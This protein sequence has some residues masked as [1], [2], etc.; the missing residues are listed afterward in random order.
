MAN[1]PLNCPYCDAER[2]GSSDEYECGMFSDGR[3]PKC[4]ERQITKLEDEKALLSMTVTAL[5]KNKNKLQ[6]RIAELEARNTEYLEALQ[7]IHN[8]AHDLSTGPTVPDGFWELREIAGG[9]L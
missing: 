8:K 7:E 5:D 4:Y 9:C 2:C 1:S 3:T 6:S